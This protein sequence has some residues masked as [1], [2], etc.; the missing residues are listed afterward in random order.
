MSSD[1]KIYQGPNEPDSSFFPRLGTWWD[2]AKHLGNFLTMAQQLQAYCLPAKYVIE[3]VSNNGT[4]YTLGTDGSWAVDSTSWNWDGDPTKWSRFWILLSNSALNVT[5]TDHL[6]LDAASNVG[7]PTPWVSSPTSRDVG[8]TTPY[9]NYTTS[10]RP[11]HD[12]LQR[13]MEVQ[14]DPHTFC[15]GILLLLDH[16]SFWASPPNGHWDRWVNRSN[17]ALYWGGTPT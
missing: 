2:V 17:F 10:P 15:D 8:S 3:I 7:Q 13:I 14:R 9:L 1:W 16:D 11:D 12:E 5:G 6:V 4:R